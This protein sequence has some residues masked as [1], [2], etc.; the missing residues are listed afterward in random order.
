[1]GRLKWPKLKLEGLEPVAERLW[2]AVGGEGMARLAEYIQARREAALLVGE[3]GEAGALALHESQG[4]VGKARAWLSQALPESTGSAK[5]LSAVKRAT[6]GELL[7]KAVA[8]NETPIRNAHLAGK[9]HPVTNVPF[10][11]D[12]YPDFKAAGVVKIEVKI[13]YTGSRTGDFAAA[14]K[15]SGLRSTPKGMTWHHHQDGTT[16]QLVPSDI[17][18]KTGHTGGFSGGR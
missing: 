8:S 7:P 9:K 18:A 3:W 12:G 2:K 6:G 13:A 15:V 17:H 1:V 16:M 11:A 5:P 4:N 14:N 10:D